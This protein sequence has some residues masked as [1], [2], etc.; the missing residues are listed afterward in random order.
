MSDSVSSVSSIKVTAI[1]RPDLTQIWQNKI[2]QN[3]LK[4]C[5][6]HS[7]QKKG[8][9]MFVSN[10]ACQAAGISWSTIFVATA[11]FTYIPKEC[12]I[13]RVMEEFIPPP[14]KKK[15]KQ[16]KI[17]KH[18]TEYTTLSTHWPLQVRGQILTL[19]LDLHFQAHLTSVLGKYHI[20]VLSRSFVFSP[21]K[22][23]TSVDLKIARYDELM[24]RV[25]A[26]HCYQVDPW[27]AIIHFDVIVRL[28]N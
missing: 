4:W 20:H 22:L 17:K 18:S 3:P 24:S 8:V 19:N 11:T 10:I 21:P 6:V 14:Q 9:S 16:K 25:Q 13:S 26:C 15:N 1:D 2:V 23:F 5:S 7:K 12:I 28:S 27:C